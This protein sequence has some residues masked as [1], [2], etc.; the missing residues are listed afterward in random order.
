MGFS[1]HTLQ[2]FFSSLQL[3]GMLEAFLSKAWRAEWDKADIEL[4]GGPRQILFG[5]F[6]PKL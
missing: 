3:M 6:S 1:G 4:V 2:L 5:D